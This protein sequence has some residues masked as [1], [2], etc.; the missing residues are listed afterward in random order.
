MRRSCVC[1]VILGLGCALFAGE[2]DPKDQAPDPT[3]AIK[4]L[5]RKLNAPEAIAREDAERELLRLGQ[6]ALPLLKEAVKAPEP[7]I[8]ARAKRL[9]SK[10]AA[11]PVHS[12]ADVMPATSIFF[13][14]APHVR[15][16]LDRL[17]GSPLGKLWDLPAMQ[18]FYKGHREAQIP[19]D[20]K[21]LDAVRAIPKLLDGKALV[22]IGPPDTAEAAEMDPPI[23]YVL[24][25]KQPHSLETQARNLF[26]GMTDQ[27]KTS[28]PYGPFIIE[29]HI[30][31]QTVFAQESVIH[32]LTQ[33]GI[34]SFLDGLKAPPEKSLAPALK[35]IRALL[36]QYDF[37][38]HIASDG[39]KDLAEAGQLLDD[40]QVDVV[41]RL[42]FM[43]GSRCQGVVAVTPDGFE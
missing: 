24:E 4:A 29:E 5:I 9:V 39:F 18:K 8:A 30:A 15:Q 17:K 40:D 23:V 33:K 20:Q 37:V 25:S 3:E 12:Y 16:T 14:E 13:L 6:A 11:R 10:M 27:P 2:P 36:P 7:E 31:A 35:E 41:D 21:M 42:G 28:R 34:E 1:A 43:S 19:N 38:Y 32:A 22:A 26:E